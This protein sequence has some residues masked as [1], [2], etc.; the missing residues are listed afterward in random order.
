MEQRQNGQDENQ[1]GEDARQ[2]HA[3]EP[4]ELDVPERSPASYRD[5]GDEE[6]GNHEERDDGVEAGPEH[7]AV[8]T[9]RQNVVHRK[10]VH[11]ELKVAVVEDHGEDA[12][13]AQDVDAGEAIAIGQLIRNTG[14]LRPVTQF[15]PRTK[16]Q[17]DAGAPA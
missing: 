14:R 9:L 10:L 16:L 13:S 17:R 4:A 2:S 12:E 5:A 6:P 7:H 11:L 15:R 3:I 8:E 1:A